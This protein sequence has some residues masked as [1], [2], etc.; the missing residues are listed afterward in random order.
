MREGGCK[1]GDEEDEVVDDI[2]GLSY[3]LEVLFSYVS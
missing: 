3:F 1:E 2:W